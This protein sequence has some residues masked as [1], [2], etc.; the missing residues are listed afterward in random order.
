VHDGRYATL[1]ALVR[2]A[3]TELRMGHTSQ[4]DEADLDAL[5]T[6]LETL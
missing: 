2:A 5:V 3:D 1:R 6:Y 4:L